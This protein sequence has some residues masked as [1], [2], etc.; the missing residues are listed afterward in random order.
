MTVSQAK[1]RDVLGIKGLLI[2]AGL[3]I[4][5]VDEALEDFRVVREGGKGKVIAC[6]G[7]E[8]FGGSGMLRSVAVA[9]EYRG[10]GIGERVVNVVLG[11]ARKH[12]L[13]EVVLLTRD[14][15]DYF[16]DFGFELVDYDHVHVTFEEELSLSPLWGHHA[17]GGAVLMVKDMYA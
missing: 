11:I 17:C 2:Q 1:G 4:V 12:N 6:G 10:K 14:A 16:A 13:F 7:I 8:V 9:E 5:G 3:P 15:M